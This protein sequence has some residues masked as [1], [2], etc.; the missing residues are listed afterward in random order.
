MLVTV[1]VALLAA[2]LLQVYSLLGVKKPTPVRC[3]R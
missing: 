3:K 2:V 1:E